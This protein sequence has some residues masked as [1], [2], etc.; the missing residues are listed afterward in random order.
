MGAAA[1]AGFEDD[2]VAETALEAMLESGVEG[3]VR[4][5]TVEGDETNRSVE[6][7]CIIQ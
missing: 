6:P 4:I 2:Y 1:E 5:G 7:E 3:A